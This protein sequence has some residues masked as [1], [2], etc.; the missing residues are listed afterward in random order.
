[1]VSKVQNLRKSKNFEIAD[2]IILYY[3][4]DELVKESIKEFEEFIKGETLSI[5]IKEKTDLIEEVN[6]NGHLTFIDVERV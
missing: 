6:L 4:S 3:N 2:R 5:D 1:M